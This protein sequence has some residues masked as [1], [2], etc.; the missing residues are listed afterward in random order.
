[1]IALIFSHVLLR[2]SGWA[3]PCGDIQ[4]I[5][6]L[7]RHESL[8]C[9]ADDTSELNMWW[10]LENSWG[11][12]PPHGRGALHLMPCSFLPLRVRVR[13]FQRACTLYYCSH[14]S[15]YKQMYKQWL[16]ETIDMIH[17]IPQDRNGPFVVLWDFAMCPGQCKRL[18]PKL[19]FEARTGL[20]P[21]STFAHT[22]IQTIS[23][24][25]KCHDPSGWKLYE[26]NLKQQCVIKSS[27]KN[28]DIPDDIFKPCLLKQLIFSTEILQRLLFVSRCSRSAGILPL[29][30][31][32]GSESG[33]KT[34]PGYCRK[35][36]WIISASGA[37][38]VGT[39]FNLAA[40]WS[41]GEPD[42]SRCLRKAKIQT[43]DSVCH[44]QLDCI[45]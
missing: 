4:P 23:I 40:T 22:S 13:K 39:C 43:S 28:N 6:I 37:P 14:C 41:F 30:R 9:W 1:M 25:F 31:S 33:N 32:V 38:W 7:W 18:F 11:S 35:W 3:K 15:I 19:R 2:W 44:M 27:E 42:Q 12:S 20:N 29:S 17:G 45:W 10:E 5:L 16:T 36:S 8:F 24:H 26:R 34:Q 21:S